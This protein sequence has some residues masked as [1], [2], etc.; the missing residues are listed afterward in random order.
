LGVLVSVQILMPLIGLQNLL[1]VGAVV[2]VGLGCFL[3]YYCRWPRMY[4]G[5]LTALVLCV[6]IYSQVDFASERLVSGVFRDGSLSDQVDSVFH[7]DG[8]TATVDVY[9]T[10]DLRVIATNGK[11]DASVALSGEL[12]PDEYT[13]VLLGALPLILNPD[14]KDVAVV[15]MGSGITSHTMLSSPAITRLDTVEIESAMI[16]GARYFD[17]ARTFNDPRSNLVVDD[18]KAFFA[19]NGQTYDLIV[20]EPSNPWVSGVASVFSREFYQTTQRYLKPDGLFVQWLHVYESNDS[21]VFSVLNAIGE[22]FSHYDIYL[23]VDGDVIIVAGE[24]VLSL[25]GHLLWQPLRESLGRIEVNNIDDLKVRFLA[26][27]EHIELLSPLYP[28]VNTDYF[29]YLDLHATRARFKNLDATVLL[30]L[31]TSLLPISEIVSE[32]YDAPAKLKLTPTSSEANVLL[33]LAMQAKMLASAIT[34]PQPKEGELTAFDQRL[35]FDVMSFGLACEQRI[36]IALWEE[37]MMGFAGAL[38]FLSPEELAPVWVRLS[39]HQCRDVASDRALQWINLLDALSRRQAG[40]VIV[41]TESLLDGR[42]MSTSIASF[43]LTAK[44]MAITAQGDYK[45]A[46]RLFKEHELVGEHTNIAIK[47]LY[48]HALQENGKALS[49]PIDM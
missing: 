43:L 25:T 1:A 30:D 3:F 4:A 37:S 38:L 19:K 17:S 42:D 11:S 33:Q 44:V 9:D 12:S 13:M 45:L 41:L 27:K 31:R 29:P 34:E 49:D 10:G 35:L 15:G 7:M 28:E 24:T 23:S 18:A 32:E 46:L 2:D 8:K 40:R 22:A 6:V 5:G 48:L 39:Q 21:L 20:S 36:D 26:S 47:L 14:A 16:D